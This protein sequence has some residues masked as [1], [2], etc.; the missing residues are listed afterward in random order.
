M[1][2]I[3]YTNIFG[4]LFVYFFDNYILI[5]S[6]MSHSGMRQSER[7]WQGKWWEIKQTEK[8]SKAAT[9]LTYFLDQASPRT[10]KKCLP[11]AVLK[12]VCRPSSCTA[13][14]VLL[15]LHCPSNTLRVVL[16]LEAMFYLHK[17]Y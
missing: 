7:V 8:Q 1:C 4:H 5:F 9:S 12:G 15:A 16:V 2:Q 14:N 13:R 11:T 3:F 17:C 6:R 10:S